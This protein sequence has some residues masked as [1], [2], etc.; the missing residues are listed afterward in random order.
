MR[1]NWSMSCTS[2]VNF[3]CKSAKDHPSPALLIKPRISSQYPPPG[4]TVDWHRCGRV[5]RLPVGPTLHALRAALPEY[6]AFGGVG[7]SGVKRHRP[8]TTVDLVSLRRC[9]Y[10]VHQQIRLSADQGLLPDV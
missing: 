9:R 3:I 1:F 2:S 6:V 4:D 10:P 8:R 5:R 7:V